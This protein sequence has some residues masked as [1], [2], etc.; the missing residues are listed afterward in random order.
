[1]RG[2]EVENE[3]SKCVC[4]NVGLYGYH[5]RER[6]IS[7]ACLDSESVIYNHSLEHIGREDD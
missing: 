6:V 2:R 7:N 5:P 3:P 1:M 4:F